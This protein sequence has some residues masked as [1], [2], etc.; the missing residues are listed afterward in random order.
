ME[1]SDFEVFIAS[2]GDALRLLETEF[3]HLKSIELPAY[4]ISYSQKPQFLKWKLLAQSPHILKTIRKEKKLIKELVQKSKFSGIISDNRWGCRHP[5]VKSVFITHQHRVLSG[6]TTY[7]SSKIQQNYI[8]EF[9]ECWIPDIPGKRNL[10]GIMGHPAATAN[11]VKYIGVLG[12]F[13]KKNL[14][15]KYD[16]AVILSGPEPQ[17]TLFEKTL[18]ENLKHSNK[19]IIFVR[20]KIDGD[21]LIAENKQIQIENYL[22][23]AALEK[24]ML[25]SGIII[26]RS[27]YSSL[28]DLTKLEKKAFLIPTPG[29]FEQEYLAKRCKELGIATY[30]QQKDFKYSKLKELTSFSGFRDLRSEVDFSSLF[31][32]FKR[33]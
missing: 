16:L 18:L 32:L 21:I 6:N 25:Q 28:M 11:N 15:I 26:C 8:A 14:E 19:K 29:Q 2:D 22:N 23:S 3:R 4:N 1:K 7:F 20:G 5:D 9:D 31:A 24:V 27:G 10:S 12:R 30:C 13:Q 17:R 33:K